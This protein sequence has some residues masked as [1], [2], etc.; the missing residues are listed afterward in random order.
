MKRVLADLRAYGYLLASNVHGL[1]MQ[2]DQCPTDS[3]GLLRLKALL[4]KTTHIEN[5]RRNEA[6]NENRSSS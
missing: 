5:C 6:A 3:P 2:W 1:S 4:Q